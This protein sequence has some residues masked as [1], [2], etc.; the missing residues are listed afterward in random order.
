MF[1]LNSFRKFVRNNYILLK[2]NIV[3]IEN[4]QIGKNLK[5]IEFYQGVY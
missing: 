5:I 4:H 3:N 1:S 2:Y